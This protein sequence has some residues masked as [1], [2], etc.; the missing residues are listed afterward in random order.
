MKRGILTLMLLLVG[1]CLW[2]QVNYDPYQDKSAQ[3]ALMEG[4]G[5]INLYVD[6]TSYMIDEYTGDILGETTGKYMEQNTEMEI[7]KYRVNQGGQFDETFYSQFLHSLRASQKKSRRNYKYILEVSPPYKGII[8]CWL[9]PKN[10]KIGIFGQP[11]VEGYLFRYDEETGE[12]FQFTRD[13][14]NID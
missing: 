10:R 4:I 12:I 1:L 6:S 9:L 11:T 8:C 13:I 14:L 2:S 5:F 7:L 3:K